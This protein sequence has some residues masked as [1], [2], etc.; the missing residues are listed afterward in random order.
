[1]V[2]ELRLDRAVDLSDSFVKDHRVELLDHL[3]RAKFTK[4]TALLAG[5]ARRVLL[6]EVFEAGSSG[7]L[8][9]ELL[10]LFFCIDK[11]VAL[12]ALDIFARIVARRINAAP[13]F[14]APFTL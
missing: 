12:L 13:P 1:M 8:G 5:R 11:D 3:A 10:A 6:G 9:L 14:S 4:C 2:A 7:N